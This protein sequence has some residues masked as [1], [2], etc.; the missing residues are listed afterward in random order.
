MISK[1]LVQC[2]EDMRQAAQDGRISLDACVRA[3][4]LL[5]KI[6][7]LPDGG[8]VGP[9]DVYSDT[10]ATWCSFLGPA[11]EYCSE[12][13]KQAAVLDAAYDGQSLA[14]EA[15]ERLKPLEKALE[16]A[17]LLSTERVALHQCA[18]ETFEIWQNGGFFARQSA[19]RRLRTIA[20]F[21]LESNR[22]GNYVAKTFDLMNEAQSAYARAQQA[23]FSANVSYKIKPGLYARIASVLGNR[24]IGVKLKTLNIGYEIE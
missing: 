21:R 3:Y 17:A 23:L 10:V 13:K 9:A 16:D 6:M 12:Y 5:E 15:Q 22:I 19:L 8:F 24:N 20:G 11:E 18:K 1:E 7:D 2:T 4:D 14:T